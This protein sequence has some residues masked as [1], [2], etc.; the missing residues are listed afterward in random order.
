M[1]QQK[2][3]EKKDMSQVNKGTLFKELET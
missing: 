1:R 2:N 3:K